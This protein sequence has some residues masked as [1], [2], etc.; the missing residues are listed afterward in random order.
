M[1]FLDKRILFIL[2]KIK[3]ILSD[4]ASAHNSRVR[5]LIHNVLKR[6]LWYKRLQPYNELTNTRNK[7]R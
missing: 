6:N 7:D 2:T 1:I 4:F 3:S 5:A